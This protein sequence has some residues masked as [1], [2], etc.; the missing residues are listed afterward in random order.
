MWKGSGVARKVLLNKGEGLHSCLFSMSVMVETISKA[1]TSFDR[2]RKYICNCGKTSFLYVL[3]IPKCEQNWELGLSTKLHGY[4]HRNYMSSNCLCEMTLFSHML[5]G[6]H[7]QV[8][9]L[10]LFDLSQIC[11]TIINWK[12]ALPLVS[13]LLWTS[14]HTEKTWRWTAILSLFLKL[15]SPSL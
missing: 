14:F 12:I 6:L 15:F 2:K 4:T 11:Q 7:L 9:L 8:Q 10:L 1:S 5:I 3:H 13:S